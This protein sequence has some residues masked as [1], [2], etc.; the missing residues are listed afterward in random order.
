[1][2][3]KN[4]FTF[5]VN[6]KV[7]VNCFDP[8]P[9]SPGPTYMLCT[10]SWHDNMMVSDNVDCNVKKF[11]NIWLSLLAVVWDYP[12]NICV[13][14]LSFYFLHN[15]LKFSTAVHLFHHLPHLVHSSMTN[16]SAICS[17]WYCFKKLLSIPFLND[18]CTPH[19]LLI[20]ILYIFS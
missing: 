20:F 15:S 10:L 8:F 1:M 19:N 16:L 17:V 13:T 6:P 18:F 5:Y 7:S 12:S 9:I 2:T 3:E 14:A 4:S 11:K